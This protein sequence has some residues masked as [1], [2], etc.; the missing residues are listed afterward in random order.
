MDKVVATY[1]GIDIL[2]NNAFDLSA[3]FSSIIGMSVEQLQRNFETGPIAY[4]RT[5]QA[6]YPY[7]EASGE[8]ASS[9]SAQ[10]PASSTWW[11]MGPTTWPKRRCAP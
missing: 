10:W 1:G 3:P 5:M 6:A 4:L 9:T 8:G 11:V 7:L 2:V